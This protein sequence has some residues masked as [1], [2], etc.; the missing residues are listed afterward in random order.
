M[1]D[2]SN[3]LQWFIYSLVS[4]HMSAPEPAHEKPDAEAMGRYIYEQIDQFTKNMQ[5]SRMLVAMYSQI[6]KDHPDSKSIHAT[7]ILRAAVVF[8]HA[9]L[10][11]FLRSLVLTTFPL[12][13]A[14]VL[15]DVPLSGQNRMGRAEKF[16]LGD[17]TRFKDLTVAQVIERS[18]RDYVSRQT[19]NNRGDLMFVVRSLGLRDSDVAGVMPKLDAML[20]RRHQIVHRGDRPIP[21]DQQWIRATSLSPKHVT[22]W[23]EATTKFVSIALT[24]ALVVKFLKPKPSKTR[25]RK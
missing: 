15:N 7:D 22:A 23:I 8:M 20:Q 10:E 17:L 21:E 12:A 18:V 16:F 14:E 9:A 11:E 6:A 25:R 2:R 3:I 24:G 13:H 4:R 19:Y 5:R 1:H